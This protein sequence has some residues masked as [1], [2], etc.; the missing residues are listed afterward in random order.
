MTWKQFLLYWP[1]VRGIHWSSPHKVSLIHRFY[2][3][4]VVQL[5]K[6]LNKQSNCWVTYD[7]IMLMRNQYNE[8]H[9]LNLNQAIISWDYDLLP[10]Q[11]QTIIQTDADLLSTGPLAINFSDISIEIQA[12]SLTKVCQENGRYFALGLN[13]LTFWL[14]HRYPPCHEG[15]FYSNLIDFFFLWV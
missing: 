6:L 10:V 13:G 15:N 3:L 8:F 7:T 1:F 11:H 5:R 2:V 12:F 14:I 9:Y 4:F